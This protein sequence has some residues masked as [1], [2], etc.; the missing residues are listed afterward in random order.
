MGSRPSD[1]DGE[2]TFVN[3]RITSAIEKRWTLE[4]WVDPRCPEPS[5]MSGEHGD[6]GKL[7]VLS[8]RD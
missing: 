8:E 5:W 3:I 4:R 7:F 2:C 6:V 1:E